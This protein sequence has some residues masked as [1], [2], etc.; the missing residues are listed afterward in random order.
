[1]KPCARSW[2]SLGAIALAAC[3]PGGRGAEAQA[4]PAAGPAAQDPSL[5]P[6]GFGSLRQDQIGIA[7]GTDQLR[8]RVIPLDERVIRLLAPDAWRSLRDMAASRS[9]DINRAARARGFDSVSTFMVTFFALE[10]QARFSPDDLNISQNSTYRPI[11]YVPITPRFSE[12]VID[13]RGQA[14]AIYIFEPG[15]AI[16][17]PFTVSYG[18]ASSDA[19]AQ[20]LE[21]LNAERAR[22]LARASSAPPRP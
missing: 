5:P 8:I 19:W 21:L 1:V 15:I 18:S 12:N 9:A 14:A 10:P 7:L 20:A 3:H 16:L 13:Q 6:A 11:G 17:R 4:V 22:V 2:L